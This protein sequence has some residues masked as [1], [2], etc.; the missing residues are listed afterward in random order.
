MMNK[1][2]SFFKKH[3]LLSTIIEIL[4]TIGLCFSASFLGGIISSVVVITVQGIV[5]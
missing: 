2:I 3:T 5:L 1:I 4:L